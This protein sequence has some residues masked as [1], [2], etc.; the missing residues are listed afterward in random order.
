[1]NPLLLW[2]PNEPNLY[3]VI[4]RLQRRGATVDTVRTYFGMRKIDFAPAS[5]LNRP[6]CCA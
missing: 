5:R 4:L 6:C 1:M 2:N 3:E